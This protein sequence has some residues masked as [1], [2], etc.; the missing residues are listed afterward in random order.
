METKRQPI[1]VLM[2]DDQPVVCSS[3]TVFDDFQVCDGHGCF[4]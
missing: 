3:L 4:Q 1:R 2:V